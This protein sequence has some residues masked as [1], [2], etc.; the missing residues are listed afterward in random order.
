MKTMKRIIS[1]LI[2]IDKNHKKINWSDESR[3]ATQEAKYQQINPHTFRLMINGTS[4]TLTL[5]KTP[6]GDWW[7][8]LGQVTHFIPNSNLRKSHTTA[9]ENPNESVAPM[10][11]KVLRLIKQAGD[12]V[13]IN[14]T[15][16]I[17]E[18]MKMEL[19][20]KAQAA[21]QLK[22]LVHS[23]GQVAIGDKLFLI[24]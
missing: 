2:S 20:M 5:C 1:R 4:H 19:P 7:G 6:R 24:E 18:A 10:P 22:L 21:G 14:D 12:T 11:G 23:G 3:G 15:V 8:K 17:L 9:V 16:L 13:A